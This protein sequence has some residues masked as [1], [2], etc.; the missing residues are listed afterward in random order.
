[1]VSI[2]WGIFWR[3]DHLTSDFYEDYA[4]EE[5]MGLVWSMGIAYDTIYSLGEMELVDIEEEERIMN[6]GREE[7]W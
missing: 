4:F 6:M 3:G 1:M 2:R 7:T 5:V